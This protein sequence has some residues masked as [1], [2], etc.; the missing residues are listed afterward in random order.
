MSIFKQ[1][2]MKYSINACGLFLR[3]MRINTTIDKKM[4]DV[5]LYCGVVNQS[6]SQQTQCSLHLTELNEACHNMCSACGS[7]FKQ[8]CPN[9]LPSC[10][11][12][13]QPTATERPKCLENKYNEL[14]TRR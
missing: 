12:I 2:A 3:T 14:L 10:R 11:T 6:S 13:K 9:N 7:C 1:N 8:E 5:C 4:K